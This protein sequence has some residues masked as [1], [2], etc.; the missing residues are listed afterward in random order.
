MERRLGEFCDNDSP[1]IVT[2]YIYLIHLRW[3]RCPYRFFSC[4]PICCSTTTSWNRRWETEVDQWYHSTKLNYRNFKRSVLR[5]T[6]GRKRR[7]ETLWPEFTKE[8]CLQTY[9]VGF[10]ASY[11]AFRRVFTNQVCKQR[12]KTHH[13]TYINL[14][15]STNLL[16]EFRPLS[17]NCS[18]DNSKLK[19]ETFQDDGCKT[20]APAIVALRSIGTFRL[21]GREHDERRLIMRV[22]VLKC[23]CWLQLEIF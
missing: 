17:S 12:V 16:C 1:G 18:V 5:V 15:L 13:M 23:P 22:N 10:R 6:P 4:L 7:E 14:G 20:H 3:F 8:V 11:D 2:S 19:G 9:S 21:S